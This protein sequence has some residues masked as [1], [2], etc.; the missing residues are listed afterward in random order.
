[1][2]FYPVSCRPIIDGVRTPRSAD[3]AW[4]CC[5]PTQG[6]L[7]PTPSAEARP[8]QLCNRSAAR[9][10]KSGDRRNH[11]SMAHGPRTV[12]PVEFRQTTHGAR[13]PHSVYLAWLSCRPTRGAL[14]PTPSVGARPHQLC[15]RSAARALKSGD[16]RNH[17]SVARGPRTVRPVEFRQT[18]YGA[19]APRSVGLAW[20]SCRLTRGA[21][22]PTPSVGARPHQHRSRLEARALRGRC[23]CAQMPRHTGHLLFAL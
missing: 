10:L 9:A 12:R 17:T 21:L 22:L 4:L 16:R 2:H 18:T 6:A 20:L 5:G 15:N 11:T 1:M 8:H 23:F 13:A 14:L 3:L 7:L 19:R